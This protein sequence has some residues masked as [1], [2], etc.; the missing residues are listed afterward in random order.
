MFYSKSDK[1]H[2]DYL[3]EDYEKFFEMPG[4]PYLRMNHVLFTDEDN[5][6][7]AAS[8][9]HLLV[10]MHGTSGELLVVSNERIRVYKI[11][12]K[13]SFLRRA[14]G[15]GIGFVPGVGEILDGI[16]S[17][18][19]LFQAAGNVK[20]WISP[21][22]RREVARRKKERMPS[23]KEARDLVWDLGSLETLAMILCYRERILLENG[24]GWNK[25]YEAN[26][27]RTSK[28]P[29][30]VSVGGKGIHFNIGGKKAFTGFAKSKWDFPALAGLLVEKNRQALEA[31]GW[32]VETT[33]E[34]TVLK[35]G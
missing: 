14:G 15:V 12:G 23:R 24:F 16:D 2:A 31:M 17:A 34:K 32:T 26:L 20:G 35:K 27:A 13:K 21:G 10:A 30:E 1:D 25:K 19:E 28:K 6:V 9:E 11:P 3:E 7:H 5:S 4:F 8:D 33:E 18:K 22:D 29:T